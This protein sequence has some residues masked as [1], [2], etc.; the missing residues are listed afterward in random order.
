MP[1]ASGRQ[2]VNKIFSW[3]S[4]VKYT[5]KKKNIAGRTKKIFND[6]AEHDKIV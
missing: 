3:L 6:F 4:N 2:W 1:T 5:A